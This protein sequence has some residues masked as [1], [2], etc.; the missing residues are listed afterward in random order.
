MDKINIID[1]HSA[2]KLTSD[3]IHSPSDRKMFMIYV[4]SMIHDTAA[5]GRHEVEVS[6]RTMDLYDVKRVQAILENELGFDCSIIIPS[7]TMVVTW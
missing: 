6:W 3:N 5:S 4:D 7:K 2:R 1:V